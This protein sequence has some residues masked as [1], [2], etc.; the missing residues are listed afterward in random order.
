M[1]ELNSPHG[2]DHQESVKAL[3]IKWNPNGDHFYFDVEEKKPAM[4]ITKREVLSEIARTFDPIGWLTPT[5]VIAKILF[6]DLW[7]ETQDWDAV[8]SNEILERW[9]T[10]QLQLRK[11]SSIKIPR[12]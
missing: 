7:R 9:N 2:F 6:Q 11:A 4:K 3:G 8:V 12:C 5:T 1:L 10:Y